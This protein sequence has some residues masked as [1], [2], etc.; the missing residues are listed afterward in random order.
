MHLPMSSLPQELLTSVIFIAFLWS[1]QVLLIRMVRGK[2]EVLSK[3]QRR[4]INLIKNGIIVSV[5]LALVLIWAP[6]LQTFA[7]SLTAFAVA[8]VVATKEMILCIKL[9]FFG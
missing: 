5:L 9:G 8:L 7:L 1:L 6:Q 2:K 3:D 4:W